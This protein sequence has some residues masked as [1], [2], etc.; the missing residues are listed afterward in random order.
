M[1]P[2]RPPPIA[3]A[4]D[5]AKIMRIARRVLVD[6]EKTRHAAAAQIFRAHGVAGP[7]ARP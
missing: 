4:Y 6:R 2:A 7:L 5:K 3:D 1:M